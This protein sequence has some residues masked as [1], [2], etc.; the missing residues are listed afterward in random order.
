MGW[1]FEDKEASPVLPGKPVP[2]SA[3]PPPSQAV[4]P[5]IDSR[6]RPIVSD[7]EFLS[8]FNSLS[9]DIPNAVSRARVALKA[10]KKSPEEVIGELERKKVDL[11]GVRQTCISEIS[12][13]EQ[14][15]TESK[16]QEIR[17]VEEAIKARNSQI[18]QL[19]GQNRVQEAEL[20]SFRQSIDA[21]QKASRDL[22]SSVET[23]HRAYT[24]K[25]AE[26]LS[27]VEPLRGT[28]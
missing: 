6:F 15:L 22:L 11:E 14:R 3:V 8:L 23:A 27:A 18:E 12:G 7:T 21:T 19:Q 16:R 2:L 20:S 24:Q 4:D 26:Q 28:Q 13:E 1:F 25:I 10:L 9:S 17:R 5:T